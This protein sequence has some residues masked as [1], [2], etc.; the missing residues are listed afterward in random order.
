MEQKQVSD[1]K[2]RK[3]VKKFKD[4]RTNVHDEEHS[5][6]LSV[7]TDD[8]KQEVETKILEQ[9]EKRFAIS[10]DFLIRDEEEGDDILSR[11]VNG[12]ETCVF[13]I[14]PES[15]QQPM[16]WRHTFSSVKVFD[17]APE[18]S[19]LAPSNFHHFRYL[20]HSVGG[21]RFSYNEEAKATVN[22][23]L[24][25]QVADF[26]EDG[27]QNLVLRLHFG[28]YAFA[29]TAS[30][31]DFPEVINSIVV[32]NTPYPNDISLKETHFV[33]FLGVLH[34]KFLGVLSSV[35]LHVPLRAALCNPRSPPIPDL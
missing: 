13:H 26:F 31:K 14:T 7:I 23:W 28:R 27:F 21:K 2:I 24:F 6:R 9:K 19:D 30:P 11:I 17:S 10:L 18:I 35:H 5:G 16:E 20:K 33:V 32:V 3:W 8:L 25:D 15:K 22:S 34:S 1:S 29:D 4:G 12:D